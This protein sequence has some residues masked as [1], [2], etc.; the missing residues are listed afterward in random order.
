MVE[1]IG[2]TLISRFP[3]MRTFKKIRQADEPLLNRNCQKEKVT[4]LIILII[5]I[6]TRFLVQGLKFKVQGLDRLPMDLGFIHKWPQ[7]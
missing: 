5:M 7:I 1:G 3:I 6:I 2:I 4:I